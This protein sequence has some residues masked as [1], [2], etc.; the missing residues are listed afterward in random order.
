MNSHLN[1]KIFILVLLNG[2]VYAQAPNS[3][4]LLQNMKE[5][6][7]KPEGYTNIYFDIN[8]RSIIQT[9]EKWDEKTYEDFVGFNDSV[10]SGSFTKPHENQYILV[11]KWNSPENFSFPHV[12][13]FGPLTQYIIFDDNYNQISKVFFEDAT[14]NLKDVID[15]DKDGI[16]EIFTTGMYCNQ[17]V[18]HSW[19]NIYYKEITEPILNYCSEMSIISVMNGEYDEGYTTYTA[20][21]G[22]FIIDVM[23][24]SKLYLSENDAR[25]I[26]EEKCQKVYNYKKGK[27]TLET[28]GKCELEGY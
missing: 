19:V 10:V 9:A 16:D 6:V 7:F 15:I 20:S 12:G 26:K 27:F 21:N 1:I 28:L 5:K 14:S 17:G 2:F 23:K 13:N 11:L 8:N 24:I 22:K 3:N 4:I 18:C 25:I